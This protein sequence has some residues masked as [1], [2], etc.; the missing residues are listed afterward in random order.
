MTYEYQKSWGGL[1][2]AAQEITKARAMRRPSTE[3]VMTRETDAYL[4]VTN[5]RNFRIRVVLEVEH[6]VT[7]DSKTLQPGESHTFK[8]PARTAVSV[9]ANANWYYSTFQVAGH[10]STIVVGQY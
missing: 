10:T 5:P 4:K 2:R 8:I 9:K 3:G 7:F 6:G 1:G